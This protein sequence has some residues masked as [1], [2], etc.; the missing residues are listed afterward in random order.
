MAEELFLFCSQL[1]S[2]SVLLLGGFW[3]TFLGAAGI[4][5]ANASRQPFYIPVQKPASSVN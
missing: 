1:Y 2:Q 3:C 4:E 5:K